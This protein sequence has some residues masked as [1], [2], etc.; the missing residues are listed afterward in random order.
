VGTWGVSID[1]DDWR[2]AARRVVLREGAASRLTPDGR[3]D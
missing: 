3:V 1:A 2:I